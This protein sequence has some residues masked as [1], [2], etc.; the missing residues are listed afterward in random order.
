MPQNSRQ[1][2]AVA[3]ESSLSPSLLPDTAMWHSP[4][5]LSTPTRPPKRAFDRARVAVAAN[6]RDVEAT[7]LDRHRAACA[8][9]QNVDILARLDGRAGR[10]DA[11]ASQ[12]AGHHPC[13]PHHHSKCHGVHSGFLEDGASCTSA[14][15]AIRHV[16][17]QLIGRRAR[18]RLSDVKQRQHGHGEQ[19]HSH[20]Q[21]FDDDQPQQHQRRV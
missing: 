6:C 17:T 7:A 2:S 13:A 9:T 5:S 15:L 12:Q 10:H 4:S 8:A 3:D 1:A 20:Q 19:Q 11:R 14:I 16:G 18:P 21:L